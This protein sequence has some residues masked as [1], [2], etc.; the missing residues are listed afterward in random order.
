MALTPRLWHPPGRDGLKLPGTYALTA[1][2]RNSAF[3]VQYWPDRAP[4]PAGSAEELL[5]HH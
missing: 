4:G 5:R 2:L 1:P 3:I